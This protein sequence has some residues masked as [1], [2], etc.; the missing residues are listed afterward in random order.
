[1]RG[2]LFGC[3]FWIR[4][5]FGFGHPPP[6]DV[7]GDLLSVAYTDRLVGSGLLLSKPW[8]RFLG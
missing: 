1:M 4:T 2:C 3:R 6:V 5:W 7:T 8:R